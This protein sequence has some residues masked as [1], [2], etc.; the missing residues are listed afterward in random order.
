MNSTITALTNLASDVFQIMS[1]PKAPL[2]ERGPMGD[3][4]LDGAPQFH[5]YSHEIK[6]GEAMKVAS[7]R[8]LEDQA[9]KSLYRN[10]GGQSVFI[11]SPRGGSRFSAEMLS[12]GLVASAV[13]LMYFRDKRA[14]EDALTGLVIENYEAVKRIAMGGAGR[15][16]VIY[17]LA[18][19]KLMPGLQITT[20]WGTIR[21]WPEQTHEQLAAYRMTRSSV[22]TAVLVSPRLTSYDLSFE[23]SPGAPRNVDVYLKEEKRLHGLLSL[24]FA[25]AAEEGNRSAPTVVFSTN[26]EPFTGDFGAVW[27]SRARPPIQHESMGPDQARAVERWAHI[28]DKEHV[29]ALQVAVDRTVSAVAE[30]QDKVDALIDAVTVW[31][32]LVGT[33]TETTF[34]VTAALTKLLEPEPA[35]RAGLRKRLGQI[36]ELRSRVVHGDAVEPSALTEAADAAIETALKAIGALYELGSEWLALKSSARADRLILGD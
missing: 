36:Y 25:L 10:K 26:V 18:G 21:S 6:S 5:D 13:R 22:A 17:G 30:R 35:A 19:V 32:S 12:D 11:Q 2:Y 9:L 24:S 3:P 20:P 31:E 34:R 29:D 23:A 33:R 8:L 27:S 7:A 4:M 15:A 14:T 16:H 28:L 1:W